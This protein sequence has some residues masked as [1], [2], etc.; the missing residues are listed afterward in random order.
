MD[1]RQANQAIKEASKE[2]KNTYYLANSLNETER[3][4]VRIYAARTK[5]GSSQVRELGSG[6]WVNKSFS[7]L[8]HQ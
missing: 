3:Y 2:G 4:G 6:K 8:Y 7:D 1:A 5:S